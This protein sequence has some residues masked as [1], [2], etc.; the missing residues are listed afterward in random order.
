[1]EYKDSSSLKSKKKLSGLSLLQDEGKLTTLAGRLVTDIHY[2]GHVG[3]PED[4]IILSALWKLSRNAAERLGSENVNQYRSLDQHRMFVRSLAPEPML[5]GL[6]TGAIIARRCVESAYLMERFFSSINVDS[7]RI[8]GTHVVVAAEQPTDIV[9]EEDED[10]E[11]HVVEW[12]KQW[13]RVRKQL[14]TVVLGDDYCNTTIIERNTYISSSKID[15]EILELEQQ[16]QKQSVKET[17]QFL[18][19]V[20]RERISLLRLRQEIL[21][22]V[23]VWTEIMEGRMDNRHAARTLETTVSNYEVPTRWRQWGGDWVLAAEMGEFLELLRERQ[24]YWRTEWNASKHSIET[25]NDHKIA[26]KVWW[27]AFSRPQSLLGVVIYDSGHGWHLGGMGD[28]V[29][30]VLDDIEETG[31]ESGAVVVTG[32]WLL[33]CHIVDGHIVDNGLDDGGKSLAPDIVL[34]R[35]HQ[36]DNDVTSEDSTESQ[37]ENDS[38]LVPVYAH[39]GS[40]MLL[41]IP[42]KQG[43][44]EEE[45]KQEKAFWSLRGVKLLVQ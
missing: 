16:H 30:R 23:N 17:S 41:Q 27:G 40:S 20:Q 12:T 29:G 6:G 36:K 18:R 21:K 35:R 3:D 32:L 10:K 26:R 15:K 31:L 38:I 34:R 13:D 14:L 7:R 39:R 24:Q 5:P 33:G 43:K 4:R 45:G 1:M 2:G 22:T 11:E 44:N 42:L 28:V 9:E 37:V 25:K 8:S 19:V